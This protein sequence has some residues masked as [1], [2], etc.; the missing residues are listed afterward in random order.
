[1]ITHCDCTHQDHE[2]QIVRTQVA[3]G[4]DFIEFLRCRVEGC[5]CS[6]FHRADF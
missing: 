2:H 3:L 5:T 4:T 6:R 1:M